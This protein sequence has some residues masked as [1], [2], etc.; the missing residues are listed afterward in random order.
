MRPTGNPLSKIVII[1]DFPTAADKKKGIPFTDGCGATLGRWLA[2]N[3]LSIRDCYLIPFDANKDV[4]TK[5]ENTKGAFCI[6]L[7]QLV[8]MVALYRRKKICLD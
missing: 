5:K 8:I 1:N 3:N 6:V 2:S 4:C 7:V